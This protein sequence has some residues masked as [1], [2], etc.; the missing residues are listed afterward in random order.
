MFSLESRLKRLDENSNPIFIT[1]DDCFEWFYILNKYVF[2]NSLDDLSYFKIG[3]RRGAWAYY[4]YEYDT[5]EQIFTSYGIKMHNRYPNKKFFVDIL[6]HELVH[7]HQ[8]LYNKGRI[9]HGPTFMSWSPKLKQ[10][11]IKLSRTYDR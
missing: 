1:E 5:N 6:A 2:D 10:K 4:E 3:R 8:A 9:N 7:H 11:G